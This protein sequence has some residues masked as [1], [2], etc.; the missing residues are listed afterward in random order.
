MNTTIIMAT[1]WWTRFI[2]LLKNRCKNGEILLLVPCKSIHTFGMRYPLDVAFLD[3]EARVLASER[4]VPLAQVRSH[5]RA[6]AVLERQSNLQASWFLV[7]ERLGISV[8]KLSST[9]E[10]ES[11]ENM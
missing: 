7:D 4:N 5:P 6:V 8:N 1:S 10:K 2:G 9:A 11:N 3:E